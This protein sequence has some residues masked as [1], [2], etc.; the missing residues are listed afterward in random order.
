MLAK[1]A[2][3]SSTAATIVAKLSSASTM[4][5]AS[6]ET[7]VPVMPMAMPMSAVFSAGASLTPSPVIATIGAAALQ[8][9]D[10]AQLVLGVDARVDRDLAHGSRERLVR[11]LLELGAGDGATVGGDAELAAR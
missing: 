9:V 3:P 11:H 2:R 8:R 10:D 4:S 1:I 7:S 5:A 6:F